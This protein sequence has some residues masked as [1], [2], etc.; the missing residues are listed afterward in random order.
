MSEAAGKKYIG[1]ANPTRNE[2]E[3]TKW[4][5]IGLA[6]NAA[7]TWAAV[8]GGASMEKVIKTQ[9]FCWAGC[10]AYQLYRKHNGMFNDMTGIIFSS[11]MT[12]L[13]SYNAFM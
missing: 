8:T 10:L 1:S 2:I 11:I 7:N 3:W 12:I 13:F 6:M 4:L 5:G 9:V